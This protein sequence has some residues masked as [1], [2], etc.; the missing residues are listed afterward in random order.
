LSF[1]LRSHAGLI[2]VPIR[3]LVIRGAEGADASTIVDTPGIAASDA[4]AADPAACPTK[5]RRV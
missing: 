5:P 4:R 3:I 2:R 1:S